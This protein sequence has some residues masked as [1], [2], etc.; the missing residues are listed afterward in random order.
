MANERLKLFTEHYPNQDGGIAQW[1][2]GIAKSIA[3][4]SIEVEVFAPAKCV[5]HG[6]P[7]SRPATLS[8]MKG[9]NWHD[10][11]DLYVFYYTV[12]TLIRNGRPRFL[13]ACWDMATVPV[14]LSKLLGFQVFTGA[15]G[16]EVARVKEGV[17][18]W[19]MR[20]TLKGSAAVIAVSR[21]TATLVE[22]ATNGRA[23][24]HVVGCGVDPEFFSPGP[25]PSYLMERYNVFGKKV[26]LTLSRITE[27]KGHELVIRA[28][29]GVMSSCP[30]VVY[31]VA[32]KGGYESKLRST[33]RNLGL[34]DHVIFCGYIAPNELVDHYNLCDVYAM[35]SR[36]IAAKGDVEG[37][38]ITYLEAGACGKPV[39]ACASG[40]VTDAVEDGVSG[41][42]V[43]P[44][45][46]A[47]VAGALSSILRDDELARRL[48]E[49][50][51]AR[52]LEA[53]TWKIIGRQ[54]EAT[55]GY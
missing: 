3:T 48:G 31:L 5:K 15:H 33:V 22:E 44:D 32:G 49:G 53:H 18:R 30:D 39:V 27:R 13:C 1:A 51:R 10:F 52:V 7:D 17:R 16:L 6:T 4:D 47:N 28:L 19:L 41:L 55:L 11:R 45:D 9:R 38:G 14:L 2:Y 54:I 40:G 21:Y 36:E 43:L 42:V 25:K 8:I 23:N 35:I 37:F 20:F 50:G 24:V 26:I 12:K 29:P 46:E 34:E